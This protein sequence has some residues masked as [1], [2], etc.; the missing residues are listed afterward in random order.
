MPLTGAEATSLNVRTA[1]VTA[2]QALADLTGYCT[3]VNKQDRKY[4][5]QK[6]KLT[7][8]EQS[9]TRLM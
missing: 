3:W 1:P 5:H 6:V 9:Q 8:A 7:E 2:S 4:C